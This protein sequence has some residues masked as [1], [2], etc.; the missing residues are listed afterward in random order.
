MKFDDILIENFGIHRERRLENLAA[1][2]LLYGPNEAG[3]STLL[4]LLRQVLFGIEVQ[5]PYLDCKGPGPMAARVEF[6]LAD[7]R[8]G[9]F[10]RQK[11]NPDKVTGELSGGATI[12]AERDLAKLIGGAG[13][14]LYRN[15]F[16]ITQRELADGTESLL[17]ANLTEALFGGGIGGL[18]TF[19]AVDQRLAQRMD[20]F[21]KPTSKTR[22]LDRLLVQL[23]QAT[24][25]QRD[26]RCLPREY[27]E[28]VGHRDQ[29]DQDCQALQATIRDLRQQS[30]HFERLLKARPVWERLIEVRTERERLEV[31]DGLT[32][33]IRAAF[34]EM[35]A[36]AVSLRDEVRQLE[37]DPALTAPPSELLP[38]EQAL[39]SASDRIAELQSH[40][41]HI[42]HLQDD[43]P[44]L[45]SERDRLRLDLEERAADYG[46]TEPPTV[47]L[48]QRE[49]LRGLLTEDVQLTLSEQEIRTSLGVVDKELGD[50]RKRLEALDDPQ[51]RDEWNDLA[52]RARAWRHQVTELERGGAAINRLR[53]DIQRLDERLALPHQPEIDSD[54][55]ALP[56]PATVREFDAEFQQQARD[57]ER[58]RERCAELRQEMGDAARSLA[59][60]DRTRTGDSRAALRTAREQRDAGWKLIRERHIEPDDSTVA[61]LA[62]RIRVWT[63][64][65]EQQLA[66]RFESAQ[67]QAD[68]FADQALLDVEWTAQRHQLANTVERLESQLAEA[69]GDL[70]AAETA[71]AAVTLRWRQVWSASGIEPASPAAMLEWLTLHADRATRLVEL[72]ALERDATT[73]ERQVQEF[74]TEIDQRL[75][76]EQPQSPDALLAKIEQRARAVEVTE[77]RREEW[78]RQLDALQLDSER[79]H[80]EELAAAAVRGG[81]Q[82]RLSRLLAELNLPEDCRIADAERILLHL[83]TVGSVRQKLA[84]VAE[85]CRTTSAA[86]EQFAGEVA[87]VCGMTDTPVNPADSAQSAAELGR[88][89]KQAQD[90][91]TESL[92]LS[93]RRVLRES[94]LRQ[95]RTKLDDVEESL[96]EMRERLGFADDQTL[97]AAV[98]IAAQADELKGDEAT[99]E[100]QL[101]LLLANDWPACETELA[102]ST[103]DE[104]RQRLDTLEEDLQA[105]EAAL[106]KQTTDLGA[107][108]LKLREL[109]SESVLDLGLHVEGLRAQLVEAADR[110]APLAITRAI[111]QRGLA[112]FEKHAQPELLKEV[113]R[114]LSTMTHGRYV[115]IRRTL[116]DDPRQPGELQLRDRLG[117]YKSPTQLSEGTRE[118]LYLAIRLAFIL[119]YCRRNEPL[120]LVMDDVM[121]K[122][123]EDRLR[124]T[125]EVLAECS[126][127]TQVLL[128]TCH[129]RTAE[130]WRAAC[131][132]APVIELGGSVTPAE[133]ATEA[134]ASTNGRRKRGVR[135]SSPATPKPDGTASL[136]PTG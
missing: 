106:T 82:A 59:D 43:L 81:W 44:R 62:D 118:Q 1:R 78:T 114:L 35:H 23:R 61:T 16:A 8:R 91:H 45:R 115:E 104:F 132:D 49:T 102:A 111:L 39:L 6:T 129:R 88:R 122:F 5:S 31:S 85:Q 74:Q 68:A 79:Q 101:R 108:E 100:N 80:G 117:G 92:R 29:L 121:V 84:E 30:S 107:A 51:S 48:V 21:F 113:A 50:Y 66:A 95:Q 134:T 55:R 20:E 24:T 2:Q 93:E 72:A 103:A 28:L 41:A 3:K 18:G 4:T 12:A 120:P 17:Q 128:L 70:T 109:G 9:W 99:L 33:A 123:D 67:R 76:T 125:L 116:T 130:L 131:P 37:I 105:A 126:Q 124:A 64:G 26:A 83:E 136:F 7:G 119:D 112:R 34:S 11:S 73:L 97:A 53:D 94:Q 32:P 15:V 89:L 96:G 40:V 87:A 58:R 98:A 10:R 69:A 38:G 65:E 13:E 127:F 86:I 133:A 14:E 135:K 60:W 25:Q 75:G 110:W 19:R 77:S 63:G 22:P 90:A 57:L 54:L 52:T 36:Q 56:L 47:T 27:D 46:S 71:Q 42:R